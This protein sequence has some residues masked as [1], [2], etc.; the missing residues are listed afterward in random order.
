[1]HMKQETPTEKPLDSP[2]LRM[3]TQVFS[4]MRKH[5]RH[6]PNYAHYHYGCSP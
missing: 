1:M 4:R 5:E 3:V 2:I 6:N